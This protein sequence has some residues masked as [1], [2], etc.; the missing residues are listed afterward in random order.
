MTNAADRLCIIP[1]RAGSKGLPHKNVRPFCGRPLLSHSVGHALDCGLFGAIAVTSDSDRYLKIAQE[2]GATHLIKRPA[3]L[4]S[5]TVG[6]IEVLLHALDWIE[7]ET[8]ATFDTVCLLQPTSPLREPDHIAAVVEKLETGDLDSVVAVMAAKA[9]PYFT[10]VEPDPGG[11]TVSL[12]KSTTRAVERRQDIPTVY[13][14]TGSVYAWTAR[15]LR[16]QR[17]SLCDRTGIVEMP[18]LNSIDIDD[19]D[20][21]AFAELAAELLA[22]R[23]HNA[24]MIANT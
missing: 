21:W 20:D 17:S 5:D 3:E 18:R 7:A 2:A 8:G 6:S 11:R 4:A 15:A 14:I 23:R 16:T 19:A 1:A 13:Q 12:S 22:T 9:S 24:E 10:L